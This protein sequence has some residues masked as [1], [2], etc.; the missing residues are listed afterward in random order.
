M[1]TA[2]FSRDEKVHASA[3]EAKGRPAIPVVSRPLLNFFG[4]YASAF[5]RRHFHSV[6]LLKNGAPQTSPDLPLVIY[7]NHSAWWDPLLCLL[8]AQR[9]FP[10]RKSFAPI[11]AGSLSR[12]AFFQR[13]GFFPVEG[14]IAGAARFLRTTDQILA[15]PDQA[16]WLTPQGEF[17]D[18]RVRPLRF[19]PGLSHIAS[20]IRAAAFLP[21]ALEYVYWEERLPE[22]LVSFGA[23]LVF[24]F[25]RKLTISETTQLFESALAAA[26]DELGA[27]AQRRSPGDWQV[28]L[29]G[30]T[31]V[32]GIYDFWRATKAKWRGE[33]FS[34]AHSDL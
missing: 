23:P 13:L 21:L 26:Q 8:L 6:R 24:S 22:V 34:P 29:E 10:E 20:R 7:L 4:R 30:R 9:F 12:Y 19:R 18:D 15:Q 14:T 2:R 27:A 31:G 3:T 25:E 5:L 16:V 28:L 33:K 1:N 11:E 17:A 32:G